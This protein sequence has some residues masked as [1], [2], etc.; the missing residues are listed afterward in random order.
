MISTPLASN[1]RDFTVERNIE[2]NFR[3]FKTQQ[4]T[5]LAI[6]KED[7]IFW[8]TAIISYINTEIDK[9]ILTIDLVVEGQV[10]GDTD[11]IFA[12]AYKHLMNEIKREGDYTIN[13]RIDFIP[14]RT[15]SFGDRSER[16]NVD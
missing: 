1:L 12:R 14:I 6:A 10:V 16:S 5:R 8:S 11:A 3:Q 2:A 15:F 7:Q 9:N 13:A 4:I